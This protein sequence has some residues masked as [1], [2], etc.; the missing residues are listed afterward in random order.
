MTDNN[1]RVAILLSTFN[2]E[3]FLR[4]QLDSLYAQD[5]PCLHIFVRDDGS[6]DGSL[7]ILRQYEREKGHMNVIASNNLGFVRSFFELL[8]AAGDGYDFYF[9]C[10]QDDVWHSAKVS[11]AVDLLGR[12]VKRGPG[13]YCGRTQYVDAQ[14][15]PLGISPDYPE[16]KIGWGNA[17]VQNVA[18]GCTMA[19][20]R[21]ARAL[22]L[23]KLPQQCLAHDWWVY[24]V[25]SAFGDVVFDRR[26]YIQYRQHG[27]NTI[28]ILKRGWRGQW[29]RVQR[30]LQ[31]SGF[32]ILDQLEEFLRIHGSQLMEERRIQVRW[33]LRTRQ[34]WQDG[35]RVAGMGFYWRMSTVDSFILR[36]LLLLRKY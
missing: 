22:L 34:R 5:H 36:V 9:F 4:E 8:Q 25:V 31:R 35:L 7:E 15:R 11:A 13:M 30:F 21:P 12:R 27:R 1:N 16:R 32:G 18:T 2:G 33:L 6:S 17:L 26:S 29:F 19:I 23:R 28:G 24:L 10:D 20:N 14:L 3:K